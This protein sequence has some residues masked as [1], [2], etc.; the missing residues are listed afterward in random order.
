MG[1]LKGRPKRP[2]FHKDV[3]CKKAAPAP[4][5][6][7]GARLPQAAGA[8]ERLPERPR[9][10]H[11]ID[12]GRPDAGIVRFRPVDEDAVVF[13]NAAGKFVG[14]HDRIAERGRQFCDRGVIREKPRVFEGVH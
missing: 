8:D 4:D 1:K 6:K 2:F 14:F 12:R 7:E 5:L 9:E 3:F 10:E 13:R 11:R